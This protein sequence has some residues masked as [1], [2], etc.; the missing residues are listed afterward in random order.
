MRQ[1]RN[2]R[3][4][5][6]FEQYREATHAPEP[7]SDFLAQV[8]ARI[9]SRRPVAWLDLLDVWAPR[10]IAA[11]LTAAALLSFGAWSFEREA[12]AAAVVR[13]SYVEALTADTMDEHDEALWT[14]AGVR[15]SR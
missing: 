11:G 5:R 14:L 7:S 12:E 9:E 13:Q 4:E 3:L 1:D 15:R 6:L 10:W 8:W 2:H